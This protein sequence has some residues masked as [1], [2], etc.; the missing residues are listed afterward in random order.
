MHMHHHTC[1]HTL[2]LM[3]QVGQHLALLNHVLLRKYTDTLTVL[4]DQVHT[5]PTLCVCVCMC[6]CMCVPP[7][8]LATQCA[9][10]SV[11]GGV[12]LQGAELTVHSD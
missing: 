7:P 12:V 6:V 11:V 5:H 9:D 8:L 1:T 4:Q 3:P 10:P 2:S